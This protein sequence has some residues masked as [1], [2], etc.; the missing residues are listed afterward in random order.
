[1]CCAS[2]NI[3]RLWPIWLRCGHEMIWVS[4]LDLVAVSITALV[5]ICFWGLAWKVVCGSNTVDPTYNFFNSGS[6][7]L[8]KS[9]WRSIQ[10]K[11]QTA[12]KHFK[13]HIYYNYT[14]GDKVLTELAGRLKSFNASWETWGESG[15]DWECG[16]S[17]LKKSSFSI[18]I[19]LQNIRQFV[20]FPSIQV[21]DY[22]IYHYC[23][24][25]SLAI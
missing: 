12:E 5:E 6:G 2:L 15:S 7:W 14:S 18:L 1:M 3:P 13:H 22:G 19:K 9:L 24:K 21:A 16:N 10:I 8:F 25:C 4:A 20:L 23:N 17:P 11:N